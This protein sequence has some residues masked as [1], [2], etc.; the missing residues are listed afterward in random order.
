MHS[1]PSVS[2]PVGRC[3]FQ[4]VVVVTM[5]LVTAGVF[6]VWVWQQGVTWAFEVAVV[7]AGWGCYGGVR[8]L[9][10][11]ATLT[12]HGQGW[13]LHDQQRNKPDVLGEV[14]VVLDFQKTLLLRW[15]PASDTLRTSTWLWLRE[16]RLSAPWHEL[17][18]AVY[19]RKDLN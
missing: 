12:W 17:R 19:Q 9:S 7:L 16:G 5:V 11:T 6:G 18:C 10:D 4:R 13:C 2:Y 8:A 15:Q 3:A 14:V 1:A